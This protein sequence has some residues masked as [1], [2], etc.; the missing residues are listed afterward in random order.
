L[1][2]EG[3]L[4]MPASVFV[5]YSHQDSALVEPV[6]QLLRGT[7]GLVFQDSTGIRPG[8]KWKD[9]IEQA[10]LACD[11]VALFWCDHSSKSPEVKAE[12]EMAIASAKAIMPV[13]LDSTPV[14]EDLV[15]FQWVDF[16]PLVGWIHASE[17][18]QGKASNHWVSRGFSS[19]SH[20]PRSMSS[21]KSAADALRVELRNR[22]L[23]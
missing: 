23:G 1:G 8:K 16:R 9:E 10:I 3:I 17:E 19:S 4:A 7:V 13:L 22:G 14:P 2:L 20:T 5:S 6:A 18:E 21:F 12:Y 11:L 15:Q